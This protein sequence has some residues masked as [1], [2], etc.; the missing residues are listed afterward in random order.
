MRPALLGF[1]LVAGAV[2]A[3]QQTK[4]LGLLLGGQ[5]YENQNW[6]ILDQ[7]LCQ[8][9]GTPLPCT[10]GGAG[11][12][13]RVAATAPFP[14]SATT[15]GVYT[16]TDCNQVCACNPG[17]AAWC[18][19]DTGA[20]G[21]AVDCCVPTTLPPTTSTTIPGQT[22]PPSWVSGMLTAY[23]LDEAAGNVRVNLQGIASRNLT[24]GSGPVA[25]D[26][27]NKMEGTAA[28]GPLTGLQNLSTTDATL[29]ALPAPFTCGF[30]A[31]P[32]GIA[33]GTILG[34]NNAS[35]NGFDVNYNNSGNWEW[36]NMGFPGLIFGTAPL[37]TWTHLVVRQSGGVS[38]P[39]Q[40][41]VA[42]T[43]A[44]RGFTPST[45]TLFV[46]G[47]QA[48]GSAFQGEVDE[49]WCSGSAV[50]DTS[51]CRI[52]ACG[53][54]GEQCLCSGT[55]YVS[56]GRKATACGNCTLPAACNQATP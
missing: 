2:Y 1:L 49:T 41:G 12:P 30:W 13:I 26:A 53:L 50:A 16:D 9:A 20:C 6:Q 23:M 54:R 36:D 51:I 3:Q 27:V 52:C 15:D 17:Q 35:T 47:G 34:V 55:A 29:I 22:L 10:N 56:T 7:V 33:S 4:N 48:S 8:T 37:N 25:A 42:S 43:A 44:S 21:S 38:Q 11:C 46:V 18:R 40:N 31:R 28:L 14:C 24:E 5:G 32:T 19:S 39:F 45:G